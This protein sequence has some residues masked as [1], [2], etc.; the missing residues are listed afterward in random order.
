MKKSLQYI[1]L[2][3]AVICVSALVWLVLFET[4]NL[5]KLQLKPFTVFW[6][7]FVLVVLVSLLLSYAP[8]K[9]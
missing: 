3:F 8:K 7:T 4:F 1:Q 2:S 5:F 6:V 9:K